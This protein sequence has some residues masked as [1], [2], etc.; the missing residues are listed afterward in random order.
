MAIAGTGAAL[1]SA[2]YFTYAVL[3]APAGNA[4]MV[5]LSD[6]V[7]T[8]AKQ[9]LRTQYKWLALWV[10]CLSIII[11]SILRRA[12]YQLAGLWTVIS[13]IVGSVLSGCAGYIGKWEHA[14][15]VPS[16]VVVVAAVVTRT[17]GA[18]AFVC[19]SCVSTVAINEFTRDIT[20]QTPDTTP[21]KRLNGVDS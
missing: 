7:H 16:V 5:R 21:P 3:K 11:G 6:M 1:I 2:V 15:C 8:S 19:V 4:E 18:G 12:D 20:G 14:A 13:Y 17:P 9:Y 10:A